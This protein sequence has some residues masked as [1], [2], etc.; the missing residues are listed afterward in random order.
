MCSYSRGLA[1][2]LNNASDEVLYQLARAVVG[3]EMQNIA[4]GQVEPLFPHSF[5][6]NQKV[7]GNDSTPPPSWARA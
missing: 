7:I 2:H 5:F 4:F 6:G 3:A 1:K